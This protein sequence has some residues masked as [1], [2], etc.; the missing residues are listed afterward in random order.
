MKVIKKI[1]KIAAIIGVLAG[2]VKLIM[3][4]M[5]L[6]KKV[7][8]TNEKAVFGGKKICYENEPFERDSIASVFSGMALDFKKATMLNKESSLDIL[9]RFSG[10]DVKVPDSW[11]IKMDGT[12]VQSGI[13]E[14]YKD[15][16]EDEE[17]PVLNINYDIKYCGLNVCNPKPDVDDEILNGDDVEE[18]LIVEDV[19]EDAF[20]MSEETKKVIED[21][22]E[23]FD[24]ETPHE[25][26]VI[27]NDS[28]EIIEEV[29]ED[30]ED[31]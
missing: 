3:R 9:G 17:A 19:V 31:K 18:E 29:V 5:N 14:K 28:E 8:E 16:S 7:A 13:N 24:N 6:S 10:I 23:T 26:E 30:E 4:V 22:E 11:H 20:E 25:P 15:N 2:T 21:F 1:L 12:S 27:L